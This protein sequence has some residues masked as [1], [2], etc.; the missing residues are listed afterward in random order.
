MYGEKQ[1]PENN[2]PVVAFIVV[3]WNN[4]DL[5]EECFDSILAQTYKH[6][7]ILYIDN[8]S[9]DDSVVFVKQKYPDIHIIE[10][11]KNT[12]FATGNN[13][14]INKALE[15]DSVGYVALLNS[16]ARIE[17]TWTETIVQFAGMKPRGATF[18]GTTF[19]YYDHS[20]VDSTHIYISHNGQGT[21]GGWRYYKQR[22]LGPRKVFGVNAAA[23][24]IT[25]DYIE[26]Q[27]FTGQLFDEA[28]FMYLEDIDLAARVTV[29][30]WDNY[31]VPRAKAYHMG[32]A[33]SG[34]NPG[35]SL[36]MTFR[37]N[38]AV[39]FKNYPLKTLLRMSPDILRG[40]IDT[41]RTLRRQNQNA[42][43]K[44]VIKGRFVGIFRLPLYISKKRTM[45]QYRTIDMG[46]LWRLM[47]RG[48]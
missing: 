5:L 13:I 9:S 47:K 32:S 24:I 3:G 1:V 12:G 27:P 28:M 41:I 22:D 29:M 46:Y 36:Y 42:A 7:S 34:K 44:K 20:I 25:R 15:D 35:F 33:S 18:Q 48:Y 10:P 23:C 39:L 30:G 17:K 4:R 16:D 45:S 26:A 19:D 40:D 38:S 43:I 14:G 8:D 11:G 21:Q 31:L 37:N 6:I 2:K